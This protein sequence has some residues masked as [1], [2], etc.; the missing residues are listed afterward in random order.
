M[1]KKLL[2]DKF[3]LVQVHDGNEEGMYSH[4]DR[5]K[6][7]RMKDYWEKHKA[8]RVFRIDRLIRMRGEGE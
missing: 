4:P 7:Q 6:V 3:E 2:S 1:E 5:G 8:G